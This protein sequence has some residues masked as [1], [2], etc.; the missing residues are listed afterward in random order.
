MIFSGITNN[1]GEVFWD[2]RKWCLYCAGPMAHLPAVCV[3]RYDICCAIS[4]SK[5]VSQSNSL[6]G[7]NENLSPNWKKKKKLWWHNS[8]MSQCC[9]TRSFIKY[10]CKVIGQFPSL[11]ATQQDSLF[12][13][14]TQ[15]YFPAHMFGGVQPL[16]TPAPGG[17]TPSSCFHKHPYRYAHMH[18]HTLK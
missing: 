1:K 4:M 17:L 18:T 13:Q 5:W 2:L 7:S 14:R 16:I 3:S 10:K 11:L 15:D 8:C 6:Y 12:F 9:K